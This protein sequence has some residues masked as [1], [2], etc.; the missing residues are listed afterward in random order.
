VAASDPERCRENARNAVRARWARTEP[1]RAADALTA[2]AERF[3]ASLEPFAPYEAAA[4]GHL[5]AI[6]DARVGGDGDG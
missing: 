3:A 6:I 5:A 1:R 2:W 4:V